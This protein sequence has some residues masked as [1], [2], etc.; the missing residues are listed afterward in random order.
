MLAL[1]DTNVLLRLHGTSNERRRECEELLRH[2]APF[3]TLCVCTQVLAEF[4][5][6]ATRPLSANG[7]GLNVDHAAV[8]V[9]QYSGGMV[10]LPDPPGLFKTWLGLV[11]RHGVT[12]KPAHDAKLAALMIC[13][14]IEHVITFNKA[15]LARFPGVRCH[16]PAEATSAGFLSG[17]G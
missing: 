13:H 6:V 15:D 12:G 16:T 14:G 10:L 1:L 4:Y 17:Q 5:V 2:A 3:G 11:R 9:E 8:R 7:L